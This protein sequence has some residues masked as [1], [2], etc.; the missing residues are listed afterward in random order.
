[1]LAQGSE[2]LIV[3]AWHDALNTGDLDR[4]GALM[5]ENVE[6]GGPRGTG[7]GAA[8]VRD[9]AKRSG[10]RLEAYQWFASDGLIVVAQRA[11]WR[12]SDTGELGPAQDIASSFHVHDGLIQ[13]VVRYDNL[14]NALD[15]A[16][17]E[18]SADGEVR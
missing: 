13:K 6:F 2:L 5:D 12:D 3:R 7:Q 14:R 10:I 1:M 8:Q 18:D 4:L 15:A 9:W 17:I 11:H 16:G